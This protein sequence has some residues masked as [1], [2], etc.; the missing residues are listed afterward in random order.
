MPIQLMV[1][2]VVY[3]FAGLFYSLGFVDPAE[4]GSC[5]SLVVAFPTVPSTCRILKD[6]ESPAESPT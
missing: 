2:H 5:R 4:F 6:T 1:S 3:T